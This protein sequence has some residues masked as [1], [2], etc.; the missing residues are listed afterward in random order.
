MSKIVVL[1][2]V[3]SL[4]SCAKKKHKI[5]DMYKGG[6][7]F[8]I[9]MWGKGLC[10]APVDI[11]S[12]VWGCQDTYIDGANGLDIGDGEQ[13]TKD[14]ISNCDLPY[15]CAKVTDDYVT[16]SYDDWYVPSISELELMYNQLYLNDFG[17]FK[18]VNYWSSSQNYSL[19]AWYL[20][21]ETG[22][23]MNNKH[24][25][26]KLFVRPIRSF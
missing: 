21:F 6:Y 17:D 1:L 25:G 14:I 13:N 18:P 4:A 16:D 2:I 9:N 23:R 11:K 24:K 10:A 20:K 15:S 22:E 7:I 12:V 26:E 5:G 3:L 19:G 8:K